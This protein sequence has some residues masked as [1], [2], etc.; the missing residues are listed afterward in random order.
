MND[1][2]A[3]SPTVD[4]VPSKPVINW[5][6]LWWVAGALIVMVAS[7]RAQDPFFLNFVHVATGVLWT[8][9]DLFMGF[10]VGPINRRMDFAARRQFTTRLMPRMLFL[11]TTLA[12]ITPTTGW[13]LAELRGFTAMPYPEY[14]WVLAALIITTILGIQGVLVLLPTN[15]RVA[16]EIAKPNPDMEKVG[17]LMRSY[18]RLVAFQGSMQLVILV[19]M[20]KFA[21][22]L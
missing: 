5:H 12:I 7:I 9:I 2:A 16:F 18:V 22:G 11:M 19:I 8:G 15:I 17:R 1:I 4:A 14:G 21:T 3:A 13:Y 10:V 6:N 20:A